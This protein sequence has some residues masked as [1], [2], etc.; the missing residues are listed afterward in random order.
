LL[1]YI[2]YW[3][4][5]WRKNPSLEGAYL[6]SKLKPANKLWTDQEKQRFL[7]AIR[8]HGKD[9]DKIAAAVGTRSRK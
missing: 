5:K 4:N 9:F 6:R 7:D 8:E 2:S 3:K 1:E